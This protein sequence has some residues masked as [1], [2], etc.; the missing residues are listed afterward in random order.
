[1][2]WVAYVDE[3]IRVE[4]GV[5]ILAAAV[6]DE[7]DAEA[8]RDQ[9]RSLPRPKGQRFHWRDQGGP[10]RLVAAELVSGLASLH[11]V[12]VGAP[13]DPRRQERA[14]RKC[15]GELLLRLQSAGVRQVWLE[16]RNP[17]ADRRDI[18]AVDAFRTQRLIHE[19]L[20]VNHGY[21]GHEELLWI[22]DIVAGAMSAAEAGNP[23]Y[24]VLL[25]RVLTVH[26]IDL[27]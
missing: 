20:R 7:A 12:V 21:P 14:R 8:V 26:R 9:V 1:M 15:L 6:L 19:R 23:R 4:S 18:T 24:R 11:V 10:G 16:A 27:R 25:K 22:A 17:I 3:S 13:L 5:Y 2:S